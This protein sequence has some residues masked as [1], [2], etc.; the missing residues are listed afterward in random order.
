MGGGGEG[1]ERKGGGIKVE[2]KKLESRPEDALGSIVETVETVDIVD[3][4]NSYLACICICICICARFLC[5]EGVEG[6]EMQLQNLVGMWSSSS[7]SF[8]R[9]FC[10]STILILYLYLHLFLYLYFWELSFVFV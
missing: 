1:E 10:W 7:L 5:F 4:C 3:L 2:R 8:G 6:F 9:Q